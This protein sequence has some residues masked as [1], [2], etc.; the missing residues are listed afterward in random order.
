MVSSRPLSA[1]ER[2]TWERCGSQILSLKCR[3]GYDER[4]WILGFE[5]TDD[6][7]LWDPFHGLEVFN[8]AIAGPAT[9]IPHRYSAVPE[10]YCILSAYAAAPEVPA[11]GE[12]LS[13]AGLDPIR[14][15]GLSPQDSAALL[16]YAECD[17]GRLRSVS[18]PFF[19]ETSRLGSWALQVR[20]LPRVSVQLILW[21]G[22]EEVDDGGTLHYDS[23]ALNLLPHLL[24]ELAAL[25]IWR[26]RNILDPGVKWG[27]HHLAD[28]LRK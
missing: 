7:R 1:Y 23:S 5:L 24:T 11:T 15:S 25:T 13:L 6:G 4:L 17:L 27:Y 20:P 21:K 2:W 9:A 19:G 26:L 3:L 14:P 8:P 12:L 16:R 28:G 10:M 18:V 22:D